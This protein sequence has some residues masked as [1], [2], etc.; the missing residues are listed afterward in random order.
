MTGPISIIFL[1]KV[2][3]VLIAVIPLRFNTNTKKEYSD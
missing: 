3:S 1:A 2:I